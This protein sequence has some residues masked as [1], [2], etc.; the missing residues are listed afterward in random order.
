MIKEIIVII[1]YVYTFLQ[2]MMSIIQ[3]KRGAK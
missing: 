2:K 1:I 3:T